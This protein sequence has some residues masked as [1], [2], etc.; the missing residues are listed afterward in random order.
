M[1]SPRAYFLGMAVS[2]QEQASELSLA[3]EW[4]L[5]DL[6]DIIR[7]A[8]EKI[9]EDE[10]VSAELWDLS[11]ATNAKSVS[12]VLAELA[13]GSAF[14]PSVAGVLRRIASIEDLSPRLAATL[15]KRIYSLG[16]R[17]D[18]P[19]AYQNLMHHWYL[20]DAAFDGTLNTPEV[21]TNDFIKDVS[22]L[23]DRQH[24]EKSF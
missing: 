9:L 8:D 6:A 7:W 13:R 20:F 5:I 11:L 19:E 21:A 24:N 12:A 10:D 3:L 17:T 22:A 16:L 18:A 4:G 14:W 1:L 23:V 2:L 15:A